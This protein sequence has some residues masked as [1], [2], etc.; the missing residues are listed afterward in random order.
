MAPRRG[1]RRNYQLSA[2]GMVVFRN[3]YQDL[4]IP[5]NTEPE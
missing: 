5:K 2:R 3:L 4:P 1:E